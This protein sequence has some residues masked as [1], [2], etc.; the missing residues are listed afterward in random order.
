MMMR[1][2]EAP[3]LAEHIQTGGHGAVIEAG[4]GGDGAQTVRG[5]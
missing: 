3:G 1:W 2:E 5:V 4:G